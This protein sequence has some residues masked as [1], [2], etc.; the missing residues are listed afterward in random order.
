MSNFQGRFKLGHGSLRLPEL[1]FA[2]PGA[3]VELAGTYGLRHETLDFKGSL[4]L[5][6]KISETQT[7]IKSILLKIIDPLFKKKNGKGSAIPIKI[8]GKRDA[9][10][11]GVDFGR[12]FHR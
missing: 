9:P 7:G 3:A 8:E 2:V 1:Q 6:A 12:V 4:L 10:S 5:D 11:F